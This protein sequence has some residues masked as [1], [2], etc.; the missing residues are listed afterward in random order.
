MKNFVGQIAAFPPKCIPHRHWQSLL[1][2]FFFWNVYRSKL[3]EVVDSESVDSVYY[4][5]SLEHISPIFSPRPWEDVRIKTDNRF[6]VAGIFGEY[7]GEYDGQVLL[8]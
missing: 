8:L 2:F 3:H 5:L 1:R 4:F 7:S 6:S